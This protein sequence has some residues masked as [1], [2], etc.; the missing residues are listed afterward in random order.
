MQ[1]VP[2]KQIQLQKWDGSNFE[3]I[4]EEADKFKDVGSQEGFSSDEEEEE[5][6]NS[7]EQIL[8][9]IDTNIKPEK[10]E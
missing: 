4:T 8:G 6:I 1:I 2:E 5:K 3:M 10:N 9:G 7:K